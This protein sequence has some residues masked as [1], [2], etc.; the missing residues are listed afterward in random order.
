MAKYTW[1]KRAEKIIDCISEHTDNTA[2]TTGLVEYEA[3]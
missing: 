2:E 3:G 1:K